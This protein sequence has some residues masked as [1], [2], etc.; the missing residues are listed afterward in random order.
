VTGISLR[1]LFATVVYTFFFY[2][3]G[4]V[5][6]TIVAYLFAIPPAIVERLLGLRNTQWAQ[7]VLYHG[8]KYCS[9]PWRLVADLSID[10]VE[11]VPEGKAVVISNHHSYIDLFLLFHVFPRIHMTARR[12]LFFIPVL[13]WA[14]GL[15]QHIPHRKSFSDDALAKAQQWLE[16]GR[17]VGIFPEGTRMPTGTIGQFGSG[18]F[19]LAQATTQQVQPVVMVGT[20]QVWPRRCF[21][22]RSLGPCALKVLPPIAVPRDLRRT[23]LRELIDSVREQMVRE[24][25]KL[26]RELGVAEDS[27]CPVHEGSSI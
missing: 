19:R 15:L 6:T 16:R 14:M 3:C 2:L 21:W 24:H 8:V 25:N 17:F 9:L 13:G 10:A 23:Q 18:A 12:S 27:A 26:E 4:V 22:I 5:W 11:R 7:T 20:G 1:Q